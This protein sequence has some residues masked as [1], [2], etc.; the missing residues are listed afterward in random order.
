MCGNDTLWN[1][2]V[3][4][5]HILFKNNTEEALDLTYKRLLIRNLNGKKKLTSYGP[6]SRCNDKKKF[7]I[8]DT[9]YCYE[10]WNNLLDWKALHFVIGKVRFFHNNFETNWFSIRKKNANLF[11][12]FHLKS[13][14]RYFELSSVTDL[15]LQ[16]QKTVQNNWCSILLQMSEE[17]WTSPLDWK[18]LHCVIGKVRL[19]HNNFEII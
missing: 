10:C 12:I 2:Q 13:R 4:K 16:W 19:F 11:S 15:A 8:I 7:R 6:C 3:C 18:A 17:C 1:P 9:V 5:R 14:H